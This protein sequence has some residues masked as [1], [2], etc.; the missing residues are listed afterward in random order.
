MLTLS[1]YLFFLLDIVIP[2]II[3]K[4]YMIVCV[5]PL[6]RE[7]NPFIYTRLFSH[8]FSPGTI[9]NKWKLVHVSLNTLL[10]RVHIHP[11]KLIQ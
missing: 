9:L 11:G 1:R 10:E 2:L 3:G 4:K 5:F 8:D 7:M 6:E